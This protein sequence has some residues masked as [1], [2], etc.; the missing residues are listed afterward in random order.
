MPL[1]PGCRI[2]IYEIV[3]PLG[4]GGM[5]EVYRARDTRLGRDVALKILPDALASDG[6]RVARLQREAKTLAALNHPH[7]AQVYGFEEARALAMEFVEGEDLA[8][9]LSRGALPIEEALPL[10][11]QVAEAIE[12][13][14][15]KGVLHRDLKPANIMLSGRGASSDAPIVKVLDFGLAKALVGDAAGAALNDS[16]TFTSPAFT[17]AGVLLGTAAYMSPEQA[18]GKEVDKRADIWAFGCVL[19]EMLSAQPAFAG[20]TLSDTLANVIKAEPDWSRLPAETPDAIRRLLRRCLAKSAHERLQ[21]IGDSRLEIQDALSAPTAQAGP[22]PVA[23]SK[24]PG[25]WGLAGLAV[26]T[27][28]TWALMAVRPGAPA[29]PEVTAPLLRYT[30]PIPPARLLGPSNFALSPDGSTL[31]YAAPSESDPSDGAIYVRSFDALQS[32]S[33]A[34]TEG[35]LRALSWSPDGRSLLTYGARMRIRGLIITDVASGTSQG[36]NQ[37]TTGSLNTFGVAWGANRILLRSTQSGLDT[38]DASQGSTASSIPRGDTA[39]R[40]WP[41]FLPDG[42]RYLF[43]QLKPG[44]GESDICLGSLAA[45]AAKCLGVRTSAN[46]Q[47]AAGTLFYVSGRSLLAH[48]FDAAAEVLRGDP[49]RLVP[50]VAVGYLGLAAFSVSQ[51]G[52]LAYRSPGAG[53]EE[54]RWYDR[55]GVASEQVGARFITLNFDLSQDGRTLAVSDGDRLWITDMARNVTAESN[56]DSGLVLSPVLSPDGERVAFGGA[57]QK[58]DVRQPSGS[59]QPVEIDTLGHDGVT[60]DWSPDGQWMALNSGWLIAMDGRSPPRQF[61]TIPADAALDEVEFSP[62]SQW[63]TFNIGR[64]GPGG[65]NVFVA[66][67]RATGERWQVSV[68]GGVQGRWSRDGREIFYLAPDGTL[69]TVGV[70]AV[71]TQLSLAPPKPLFATGLRVSPIV[72]Q[73]KVGPDGR[74]LFSKP[75]TPPDRETVTIVI[76]W[77]QLMKQPAKQP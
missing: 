29:A 11:A 10:A 46:V 16:P 1:V 48:E 51:N 69:M 45:A 77:P 18:R 23:A 61:A 70:R 53:L 8:T 17:Q 71:G 52:R 75:V 55:S 14:H 35:N 58:V 27:V 12:Y 19:F 64:N 59:G 34:G 40:A 25:I 15:Q 30:V 47:L 7:I 63:V 62:D 32:R 74:F 60:E 21:D 38:I 65:T 73:Y 43:T 76:N 72:D 50:E 54:M 31:A 9:R 13:A 37:P 24:V 26:G 49:V 67:V 36:V 6:D 28:L 3:S 2:G 39:L 5:G 56:F 57:D 42:R 68:N 20:A 44:R 66:P 33:V 4:A 41:Y 22:K